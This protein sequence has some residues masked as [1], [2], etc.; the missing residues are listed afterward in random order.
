[1]LFS[2]TCL[3]VPGQRGGRRHKSSLA[4]RVNKAVSDFPTVVQSSQGD[5]RQKLSAS[6]S[7]SNFAARVSSKLEEGDVK[8]AVQLA[9]SDMSLAPFDESTADVL[10]GKH[11]ART[12][13]STPPSPTSIDA[14]LT[15]SSHDIQ[16]A[17]RSFR[18]G[19]AGGLDGLRPQHLKDM[20]SGLTGDAGIRLLSNLTE[21]VNLCLSGR[22]PEVI[23]PVFFGASLC[24]LNKKD[25]GIRPIA[26]GCTL[27]RLSAKAA[28]NVLKAKMSVAFY[29]TQLGFGIPRATEA[30]AHAARCYIQHLQQGYG[31]LKLDFSN[32]FNSVFRDVM[33]QTV[34]DQLPELYRFVHLC[35]SKSSHLRF[36][37][38]LLTSDEGA[39]QG[40]PLGPMLYCMATLQ[41][42]RCVT[43]ELNIWYLDDG[44]IGGHID[45]LC[46]DLFA[47]KTA[48]GQ[49]GLQLNEAKCEIITDDTAVYHR[50]RD[51]APAVRHVSCSKA[52]LLGAPVGDA[53]CVDDTLNEKLTNF[54]HLADN[55]LQL[56]SHDALFLLRHCFSTPKLLYCLRSSP[57]FS[58][59]VLLQYDDIIIQTLQQLLNVQM[60]A[61]AHNQAT[62]PV[63][64]GGL[65]VRLAS[66]LALPAFLSSTVSSSDT[67]Q[68]LLPARLRSVGGVH[69]ASYISAVHEWQSSAAVPPPDTLLQ[70]AWDLP[71]IRVKSEAVM[72]AAQNQADLARLIALSSRHAG[73]FLNALPSSA[74]GTRL[75][76]TS[77][78]IAVGL[79]L[80]LNVCAPH[81]CVCGEQVSTSGTHGLACRKSA[82]RHFRHNAVND[83]IK[84]ALASAETPAILEPASLC[85]SD[86]KRPDGLTIVPWDRGRSLVWDFTCP[87]T[88]ASSHLNKAVLSA[89]AVANEAEE[90]KKSKYSCLPSLYDFTPI[91]VETFGAVGESAMDFLEE[92]GRRIARTTAEPRSFMFLMQRLS[93]AVQRGNAVCVMG[94]APSSTSLDNEVALL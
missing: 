87:D 70:K 42:T 67:V 72:N 68:Q 29:P 18:P 11:P 25:G 74:V 64:F 34:H 76:N 57:C 26:V 77:L 90:K 92:L 61:T 63:A 43:S 89:G 80:G 79:R 78:R 13:V 59:Q 16:Q 6:R 85:R 20:T 21:F 24:A 71:L 39:Q 8:G 45:D 66:D 84:R 30:A 36:G 31:V 75:D 91:A 40:D 62:L 22:V 73:D 4:T 9:A 86:G 65:G 47:I 46:N 94:T 51:I 69:D 44:T 82:G 27:R 32:A 60:T 56:N 37:D 55:L 17:I 1:L 48:G 5:R 38:I 54:R 28:C 15:L 33:L 2:Y 23:Q 14:C 52:V 19:S 12:A 81:V 88:L 7:T 50:L 41:L 58:S 35:Y 83:L 93:V 3:G 53:S 10:R 49:V